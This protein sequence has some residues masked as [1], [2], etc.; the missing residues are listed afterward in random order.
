MTL[1]CRNFLEQLGAAPDFRLLEMDNICRPLTPCIKPK[2]CRSI[3]RD[4]VC[5]CRDLSEG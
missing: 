5:I 3:L 1:V 2:T 4:E